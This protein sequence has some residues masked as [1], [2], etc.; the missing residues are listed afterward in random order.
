LLFPV[1]FCD[2]NPMI[3]TIITGLLILV[4]IEGF[5]QPDH[6]PF[7]TDN[8]EF[9]VVIEKE[10]VKDLDS[11]Y[12]AETSGGYNFINGRNYMPYYLRS[13]HKPVLNYERERTASLTYNGR[14]YRNLVLQYDTFLDKVI[15]GIKSTTS[16]DVVRQ[17]ALT[18]DNISRFV[19]FFDDDTLT[20][21]NISAKQYP[22]FN[23]EDGFYEVVYDGR[24]KYF[25]RH[26]STHYKL[27]GVDEYSYDP[28]GFVLTG[29][30]FVRI[31][32]RK[33]FVNLF[34]NRSKEIKQYIKEK[35]IRIPKADKHQIV[36]ILRFYESIET[37]SL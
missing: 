15:Y 6:L 27:N 31:T 20:F 11:L 12:E 21:R 2:I 29:N 9:F 18:S 37:G 16:N 10:Q 1:V 19:L 24:C 32:S 8:S 14:V 7:N 17:V 23:L 28:S 25:L 22:A 26:K 5:P 36:D 30:G 33:Q 35:K 13:E 34:G 3:K 4:S